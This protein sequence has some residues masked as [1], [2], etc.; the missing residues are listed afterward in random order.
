MSA[1]AISMH[2]DC[3]RD[4]E[5]GY[6]CPNGCKCDCHGT[7]GKGTAR[8]RLGDIVAVGGFPTYGRVIRVDKYGDV[9]VRFIHEVGPGDRVRLVCRYVGEDEK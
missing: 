3:T 5:R 9:T 6:V 2:D 4:D 1:S 8:Y 7:S